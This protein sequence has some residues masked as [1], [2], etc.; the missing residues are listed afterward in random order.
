MYAVSISGVSFASVMR[1][2]IN[3]GANLWGPNK[4]A[5]NV[6][7]ESIV[8]GPSIVF[9][10]YHRAGETKIRSRKHDDCKMCQKI[11]GFDA[12]SLYLYTMKFPMPCGP[13]KVVKYSN[14][15]TI[16]PSTWLKNSVLNGSWFGFAQVDIEVPKKLWPVFEEFCPLFVN[17]V[18]P[19]DAVSNF[20][21]DYLEKTGRTRGKGK[22]LVGALSAQKMLIYAPLLKWY[23]EHGLEIT[24]IHLTIKYKPEVVF[25]WFVE[26]VTEERRKGDVDRNKALF[27]DMFKLLGNST[28]G[29]FIDNLEDQ[30]NITYTKDEKV[31]DRTLRS[32]FFSDMNEIGE[33]YELKSRKQRVTI[34]RPFHAGIA[35]YQLAKL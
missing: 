8:G 33:A 6:L 32:A 27:A 31:V 16:G 2:S 20:S 30:T 19:E 35:V 29:K 1:G 28:Y 17:K 7:R 10:R 34:D 18:L 23:L 26:K 4:E 25:D 13:G 22:K 12:N 9:T 11:V 24:K 14:D 3:R 21:L 15:Q 5:Y